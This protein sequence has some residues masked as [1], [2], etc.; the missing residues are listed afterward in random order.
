MRRVRLF[1]QGSSFDAELPWSLYEVSLSANEPVAAF[2]G[3]GCLKASD[4]SQS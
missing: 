2:G 3:H 1:N 4:A